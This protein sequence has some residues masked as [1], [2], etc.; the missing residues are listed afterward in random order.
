MLSKKPETKDEQ[1]RHARYLEG[2]T[3]ADARKMIDWFQPYQQ[4]TNMIRQGLKQLHDLD[5]IDKHRLVRPGVVILAAAE[6]SPHVLISP[7]DVEPGNELFR[8]A[9]AAGISESAILYQ[10]GFWEDRI[11][12]KH[13]SELRQI[14]ESVIDKVSV[15]FGPTS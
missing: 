1:N 5:I 7:E 14:V 15:F 3:D 10:L 4:P 2:I 11:T 13:L 12:P 9:E 6:P 8:V